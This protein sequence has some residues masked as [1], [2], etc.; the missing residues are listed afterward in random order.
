M[1]SEN[2]YESPIIPPI[3]TAGPLRRS[4]SWQSGAAWIIPLVW[5]VAGCAPSF[6]MG[7]PLLFV[8]GSFV[9][10][11]LGWWFTF[12]A[13]TRFA[14][15]GRGLRELVA[16]IAL[17]LLVTFYFGVCI[18]QTAVAINQVERVRPPSK[19]QPVDE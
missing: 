13:F 5:I 8:L 10:A 15:E 1:S 9:V 14:V 16:G 11:V 4:K 19:Y 12:V 18:W 7:G 17:N 3:S 6:L 2:P